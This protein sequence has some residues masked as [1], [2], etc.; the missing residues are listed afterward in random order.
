[1]VFLDC[2]V[3]EN[4]KSSEIF[5]DSVLTDRIT[6]QH[7]Q[8]VFDSSLSG[9]TNIL[10]GPIYL[11]NGLLN[12]AWPELENPIFWQTVEE[13]QGSFACH[14]DGQV[15]VNKDISPHTIFAQLDI[16]RSILIALLIAQ[17]T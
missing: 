9:E 10:I 4:K 17:Q 11:C 3:Y 8:Q 2:C 5:V 12:D 1:L 6:C 15:V 13:E 14:L 16:V 7:Q